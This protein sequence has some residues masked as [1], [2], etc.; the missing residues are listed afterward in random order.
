[1]SEEVDEEIDGEKVLCKR[2]VEWTRNVDLD[3][4]VKID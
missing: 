4:G 2:I 3:T 1:M